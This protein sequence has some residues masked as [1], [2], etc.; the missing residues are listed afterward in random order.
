MGRSKYRSNEARGPILVVKSSN[1]VAR[2]RLQAQSCKMLT[3]ILP[4]KT[5]KWG[6]MHFQWEYA[7]LCL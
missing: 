1:D 3:P 4:V 5:Q 2:E 6:S 7:W